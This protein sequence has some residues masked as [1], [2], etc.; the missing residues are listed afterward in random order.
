MNIHL[1][2]L[3]GAAHLAAE[4]AVDAGQLTAVH[5]DVLQWVAV[6]QRW[7]VLLVLQ[8]GEVTGVKRRNFLFF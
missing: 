5:L 4:G 7:R 1:Q 8:W 6:G 2:T 3:D